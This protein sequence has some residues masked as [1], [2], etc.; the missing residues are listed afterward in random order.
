MAYV[1]K[2]WLVGRDRFG[3]TFEQYWSLFMPVLFLCSGLAV[4]TIEL[5]NMNVVVGL[6]KLRYET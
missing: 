4:I 5:G 1:T 2:Q 6:R 3:G